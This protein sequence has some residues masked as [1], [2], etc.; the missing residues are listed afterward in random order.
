M[1]Q[2]SKS[3]GDTTVRGPVSSAAQNAPTLLSILWITPEAQ[4]TWIRDG[5]SIG[6]EGCDT[7]LKLPSV[8]RRHAELLVRDDRPILRD[9]NS[10]NHIFV[11]GVRVL[12]QAV[13]HGDVIRLGDAVGLVLAQH[14]TGSSSAFEEIRPGFYGGSTLQAALAHAKIAAPKLRTIVVQGES[15][16]GKEPTARVI[17]DWSGRKGKL[18]AV[19]CGALVESIV[20]S[21]LFGH[22]RGSFSGAVSDREGRIRAAA[23]GTLFLDEILNLSLST[24][25]KLLRVLQEGE[26]IAVGES[27][28]V[29]VELGVIV[30]AQSPLEEAV[31]RGE[32]RHDLWRRLEGL[33]VELPSLRAR[34]EDILPLYRRFFG[35]DLPPLEARLVEALLLYEWPGNLRQL[36][37]C[38]EAT[39]AIHGHK[40]SLGKDSLPN[41]IRDSLQTL[42]AEPAPQPGPKRERDSNTQEEVILQVLAALRAADGNV[43]QAAKLLPGK[44]RNFVNRV[45]RNAPERFA[46]EG[47]GARAKSG[48]EPPG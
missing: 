41:N 12:E 40:P 27:E 6:R 18:I 24:Q 48:E 21:E 26:V 34:K 36:K 31:K 28:G 3:S 42:R 33:T 45:M 15:G 23:N 44:D 9:L 4:T 37:A 10:A 8:S 11:N 2:Y 19:D 13:R 14:V 17:H 25:A 46:R 5:H 7:T 1:A 38:A 16:A 30:G 29:H 22:K 20:E 35:S 32:F 43:S 47:F 39:R